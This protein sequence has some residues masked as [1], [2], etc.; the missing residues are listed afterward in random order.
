M[1]TKEAIP[2]RP[3]SSTRPVLQNACGAPANFLTGNTP[4]SKRR[5][6]SDRPRPPWNAR[7]AGH[8]T[9]T[10]L[11]NRRPDA[12]IDLPSLDAAPPFSE[13]DRRISFDSDENESGRPTLRNLTCMPELQESGE[14]S[15]SAGV[16]PHSV[17]V[18]RRATQNAQRAGERSPITR[19]A[20]R[21]THTRSCRSSPSTERP[22][23]TRASRNCFSSA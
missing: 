22:T 9:L 18:L 21:P 23:S 4:L 7:R 19:N 15:P 14:L 8:R 1:R 11:R 20:D 13:I 3:Y 6:L 12:E 17:S 2:E 5:E 10:C 16:C